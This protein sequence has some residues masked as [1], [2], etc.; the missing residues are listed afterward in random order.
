MKTLD[1]KLN[2]SFTT[3][4]QLIQLI[5]EIDLFRGKWDHLEH[6]HPV[7]LQELKGMATIQS[8]G[9]STRIEGATLSDAE[10][11]QLIADLKVNKLENRDEQEVVGYYD[12]LELIFDNAEDI[13]LTENYIM[14]LHTLLLRYSTKDSGQKGAYKK[15]S[16]K[17]VASYPDGTQRVIFN[18]TEPYLVPK[19]MEELLSWT[20]TCL[21][22]QKYHPLLV[23]GLFIYEFLSIHPFHDGNGRL[24]R[25]LTTLLL[26]K[27][28]YDFIQY[29]SFEHIIENRKERYYAALMECQR[30]RNTDEE[31]L[32]TWMLFFLNALKLVTVKLSLKMS[33]RSG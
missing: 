32:D 22:T 24:S 29:I 14:Q 12:V 33:N 19:E 3:N 7:F 5:A 26:I 15:V 18:T 6:L 2:F 1:Q 11:E 27:L 8:I 17:V 23:V 21:E 20:K 13:Q 10:I 30:Q 28:D 16:N 9:S 31:H 4:Q 25:L